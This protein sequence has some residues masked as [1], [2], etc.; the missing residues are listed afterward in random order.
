M[1][2]RSA[3]SYRRKDGTLVRVPAKRIEDR[4]KPGKGPKLI[5]PLRKGSLRKHGYSTSKSSSARHAALRK[6]MRS[7]GA[8]SV[9]RK[10]NAVATLEKRTAPS[11]SK[12]LLAD[13]NWVKRN[14]QIGSKTRS[15]SSSPSKG[16]GKVYKGSNGGRYVLRKSK[17]T[18]KY[19]RK[20]L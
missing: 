3:Y 13:R 4:G 15:R 7:E 12:I 6:A 16:K 18:G 14:S 10:L 19:Y 8:L 17:S 2:T 5:G 11:K 1:I 20:Y 9:F